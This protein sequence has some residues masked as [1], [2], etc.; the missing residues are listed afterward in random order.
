MTK[1]CYSCTLSN[2]VRQQ[3]LAVLINEDALHQEYLK[4][5]CKPVSRSRGEMTSYSK[6]DD[7]RG[8]FVSASGAW[9]VC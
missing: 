2:N 9:E 6:P 1:S 4:L 3:V 7:S 5:S 8:A